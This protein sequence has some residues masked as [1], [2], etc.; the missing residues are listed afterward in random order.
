MAKPTLADR[1]TAAIQANDAKSGAIPT[2][3]GP[4][5]IP[6][7]SYMTATD[8]YETQIGFDNPLMGNAPGS[9]R[10]M[11]QVYEQ[12]QAH[13]P[14]TNLRTSGGANSNAIA[15]L[16]GGITQNPVAP[17]TTWAVVPQMMLPV[18]ATGPIHVI[19]NV[20][21]RSS[22]N[23]DDAS[24]AIYR[25]GNLIGNKV[26]HLMATVGSPTLVQVSL[27][28]SPPI[29]QHIYALYWSPGTGTL[30]AHSNQR[31]MYLMNLTPQ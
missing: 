24:F 6:A 3:R 17:A 22:S 28:D 18:K 29:G 19:A 7:R 30:T 1:I 25:D 14:V 20:T 2:G 31:N 21:V 12:Q 9:A 5:P 27:V 11:F 15:A 23:N 8:S 26:T 10:P 13:I 16:Q 4:Q